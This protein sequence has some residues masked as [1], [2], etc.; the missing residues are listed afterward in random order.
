MSFR[1][2]GKT[3]YEVKVKYRYSV[4]G[5]TY[6]GSRL[7]FGYVSSSG[8]QIHQDIL[9][10][11]KSGSSVKVRYNRRNPAISTLSYGIHRSIKLVL[12]FAI[13]WLAFSWI[14]WWVVYQPDDVLLKNLEVILK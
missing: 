8:R 6:T 3:S 5:R 9:N 13:I 7:A 10:R 14:F 2:N 11:L 4:R 1:I 12:E